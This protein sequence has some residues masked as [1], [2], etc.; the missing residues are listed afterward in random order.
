M[1]IENAGKQKRGRKPKANPQANRLMIRLNSKDHKRFLQMYE[2]SERSSY[3][4]FIAD[5]VLNKPLKVTEINKS[6]IDFVVLLSSF[7]AQFRAIKTNFNQVYRSLFKNFGEQKAV[8][9]I[10]IVAD[11][12]VQFRELKNEIEETTER[13]ESRCYLPREWPKSDLWS[14][15][16]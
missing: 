10:R 6:V 8:E 11:S 5:C 14:Y 2:R 1:S 9:M 13:T 3:S 7:F 12:T 16:Y 15:F 4:A